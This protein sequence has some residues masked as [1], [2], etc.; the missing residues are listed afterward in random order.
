MIHPDQCGRYVKPANNSEGSAAEPVEP[1]AET[2]GNVGQQST[3][4]AALSRRQ[5]VEQKLGLLQIKCV[6]AFS[7]P[8]ID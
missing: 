7:E 8:A 3:H 2:K 6:K 1:R 4:R 5:L